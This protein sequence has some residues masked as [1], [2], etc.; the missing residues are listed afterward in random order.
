MSEG[1]G[2]H[3]GRTFGAI[4]I[5]LLLALLLLGAVL[6]WREGTMNM[7]VGRSEG[8]TVTEEVRVPPM[9]VLVPAQTEVATFAL[10]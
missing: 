10:G 3:V 1:S 4:G 8:V 7:G 5:G 6:L 9:D 2:F